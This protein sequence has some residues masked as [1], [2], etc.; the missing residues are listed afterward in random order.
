MG[1]KQETKNSE[2]L[3]RKSAKEIGSNKP[4]RKQK[5]DNS[6]TKETQPKLES[7]KVAN[8]IDILIGDSELKVLEAEQNAGCNTHDLNLIKEKTVASN[9]ESSRINLNL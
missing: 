8:V 1:N 9:N 4:K 6:K 3:E 2:S 5:R 7:L